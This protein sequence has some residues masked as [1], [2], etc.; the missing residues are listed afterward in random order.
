MRHH[1]MRLIAVAGILCIL[2]ACITTATPDGNIERR[3]DPHALAIAE[4]ALQLASDAYWD[5]VARQDADQG[6]IDRRREAMEQ[7]I[8]IVEIIRDAYPPPEG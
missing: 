2:T 5:Y 8:R 3:P 4:T 1:L 7:W 6:E